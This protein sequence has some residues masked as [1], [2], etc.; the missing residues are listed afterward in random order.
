MQDWLVP[1]RR[2]FGCRRIY[3]TCLVFFLDLQIQRLPRRIF[4]NESRFYRS[5]SPSRGCYTSYLRSRT[6]LEWGFYYR[7]CGSSPHLW[8]SHRH[9]AWWI[10]CS[11]RIAVWIAVRRRSSCRKNRRMSPRRFLVI[12][13]RCCPRCSQITHRLPYCSLKKCRKCY[14]HSCCTPL[15]IIPLCCPHAWRS[16]VVSSA[17]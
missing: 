17:M 5:S 12:A 10:S 2:V 1:P 9:S 16:V 4:R 13:A 7:T 11:R 14:H 8:T 15:L 3:H 6:S